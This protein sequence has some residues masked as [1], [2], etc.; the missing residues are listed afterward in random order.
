MRWGPNPI[1]PF[2][3]RPFFPRVL[4]FQCFEKDWR[5]CRVFC[6]HPIHVSFG[7]PNAC[8]GF[9]LAARKMICIIRCVL[10]S[11]GVEPGEIQAGMSMLSMLY[12]PS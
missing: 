7:T 1:F 2:K 8:R 11:C 12:S 9:E 10:H 4:L 6:V 5:W 3:V